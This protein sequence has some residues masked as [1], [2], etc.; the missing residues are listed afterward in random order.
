MTFYKYFFILTVSICVA[1]CVQP[2]FKKTVTFLLDAYQIKNIKSVGIRGNDKPLNWDANT[3]MNAVV[4]DSL[5][6]CTATF[7]TGYKFTEVKFV[8]NDKFELT[9]RGNRKILFSDKDSSEYAAVFDQ[10]Q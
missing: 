6:T 9:E 7:I 5:Y 10:N 1:S 8:I 3:E 4:Q 2:S